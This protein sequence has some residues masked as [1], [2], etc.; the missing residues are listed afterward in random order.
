Q[1]F[2]GQF[3]SHCFYEPSGDECPKMYSR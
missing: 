2:V 3:K 1:P